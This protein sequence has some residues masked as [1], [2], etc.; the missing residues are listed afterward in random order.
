MVGWLSATYVL[1]IRRVACW[2]LIMQTM[3]CS[4]GRASSAYFSLF[5]CISLARRSRMAH[6]VIGFTSI[7]RPKIARQLSGFAFRKAAAFFFARRHLIWRVHSSI[8]SVPVSGR[9]F[10]AD[11]SRPCLLLWCLR[12][13]VGEANCFLHSMQT[14]SMVGASFFS[15]SSSSFA[16]FSSS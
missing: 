15:F 16:S 8:F 12:I 1:N 11:N 7:R 6:L 10:L 9:P 14:D 5:V 13:V 4:I 3:V 2:F